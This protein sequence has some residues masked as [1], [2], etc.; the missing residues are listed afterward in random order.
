MEGD[1]SRLGGG[2]AWGWSGFGRGAGRGRGM[3]RGRMTGRGGGGRWAWR[4]SAP[5]SDDDAPAPDRASELSLLERQAEFMERSF[6]E[7]KNA[8]KAMTREKS[9]TT[10]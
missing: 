2:G 8:I 10:E 3:M 9:E 6:Q 7:I 5:W 1:D 4:F